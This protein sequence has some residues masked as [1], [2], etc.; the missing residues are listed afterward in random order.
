M[1][2]PRPYN[3]SPDP[4]LARLAIDTLDSLVMEFVGLTPDPYTPVGD[5]GRRL[6]DT[7]PFAGAAVATFGGL[8][9]PSLIAAK[10][11]W[12]LLPTGSESDD[13]E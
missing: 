2:T 7:N 10:G 5:W 12:T 3:A 8:P 11:I 9:V 4:E 6:T 13:C 1:D